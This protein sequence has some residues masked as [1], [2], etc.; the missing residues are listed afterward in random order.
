[1]RKVVLTKSEMFMAALTGVQRQIESVA[2]GR[3]D[4]HG[5]DGQDGWGI[6]IEGAMAEIAVAKALNRYWDAGV[7][8][9]KAGDV[10]NI[11]VRHTKLAGGRLIVR[12]GDTS[13]DVF[14]LV[15]GTSPAYSV[16]G[17]IRG[18]DA[19]KEEYWQAPAGRP[20]AYFVPQSHLHNL[21]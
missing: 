9:F 13:E 20:G 3:K 11:Q 8:T 12:E 10:G 16:L 21:K 2:D 19:K 6:H 14:V 1:M 5:Y 18:M 4:K 7:N 17:W 15:T